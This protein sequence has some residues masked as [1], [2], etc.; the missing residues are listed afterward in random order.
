MIPRHSLRPVRRLPLVAVAVVLGFLGSGA[1]VWQASQAAY[2]A[3]T[4]VTANT[5][6]SG[7]VAITNERA[8]QLIFTSGTSNLAPGD[9]GT[10]CVEVT[11]S[12]SLAAQVK[13]YASTYA[14]T[15]LGQYLVLTLEEGTGGD[16]ASCAGFTATS[17]LINAQ[18]A[19]TA[20][21]AG[22]HS[23]FATGYYGTWSPTGTDTRTY[24]LTYSLPMA[25]T[26]GSGTDV[27]IAFSWAAQS[28]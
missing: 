3:Q 23:S 11:Y 21:G 8:G 22:A 4:S 26:G 18:T 24:R 27:E 9:S 6:D 13:V 15:G 28:T 25:T 10:R 17:T 12:G 1:L 5:F 14:S 16:H 7:G 19:D 2:S 20:F